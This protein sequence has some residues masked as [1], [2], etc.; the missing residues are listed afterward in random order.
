MNTNPKG[1]NPMNLE[2]IQHAASKLAALTEQADAIR[3]TIE[4]ETPT[5]DALRE[6]VNSWGTL[7]NRD[8]LTVE[9][10]H[11][12]WRFTPHSSGA[13]LDA[14][15][16]AIITRDNDKQRAALTVRIRANY[17]AETVT[18]PSWETND[19]RTLTFSAYIENADLPEAARKLIS[20][21][22]HATWEQ[23]APPMPQLWNEALTA[24]TAAR[25]RTAKQYDDPARI[26]AN[27]A[28]QQ[29]N[30]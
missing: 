6:A 10:T 23:I 9:A 1:P 18:A 25:V 27:L 8:R 30:A 29:V 7:R 19:G 17:D 16:H 15:C 20:D 12:A 11:T 5:L 3:E 14:T 2:Q 24:E 26:A 21:K 28:R 13:Y 22:L 4:A